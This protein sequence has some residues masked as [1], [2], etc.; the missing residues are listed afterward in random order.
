MNKRRSLPATLLLLGLLPWLAACANQDTNPAPEMDLAEVSAELE[1]ASREVRE[2]LATENISLSSDDAGAPDA[3]IT[4]A[5]ELLIDGQAV[6]TTPEQKA[7]LLDYREGIAA[8]AMAGADI[9]LQGADLATRAVS[10]TFRGLLTGNTG[11]IEKEVEAEAEK[12]KQQALK[13]CDRLP[14]LLDAQQ[15]LQASLPEFAPYATMDGNDIGDCR[16]GI[17]K[18]A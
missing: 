15:R 10:A 1:K 16:D 5:G 6:A 7:L 13:L 14:A 3:E 4:P 17:A 11:E 12:I 9:G 2:E 8:V 18:E